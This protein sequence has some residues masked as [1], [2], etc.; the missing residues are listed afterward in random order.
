M[1]R[2]PLALVLVF[3]STINQFGQAAPRPP[4]V[5][6]ASTAP[7]VDPAVAAAEKIA[8]QVTLSE[9]VLNEVQ[10]LRLSEN[11]AH[12]YARIGALLWK[13]DQKTAKDLF[14][15]A[16]NDMLNAQMAAEADEK[17]RANGN[18]LRTAISVRPNIL[19]A[20]GSLDGEF[21]LESLFRTRTPAIQRAMMQAGT[22][23]DGKV[24]DS[25]GNS[26][27]VANN[28]LML[29]QRLNRL[30][31]EQNPDR[32]AKLLQ[33]SIRKGLSNETLGLLRKL[34]QKDPETGESLAGEV[35][36][37]LLGESFSTDP[38]D[39]QAIRLS[40]AILND[41]LRVRKP[42]VKELSFTEPNL[43][44]LANK[45]INYAISAGQNIRNSGLGIPPM[46]KFAEKYSPGMVAALKKLEKSM[47]PPGSAG[48][49]PDSDAR[50]LLESSMTP[51]QLI[52]EAK[53]L[54][55][56]SRAPVYQN[57]ANR[58]SQSGDIDGA[59]ALLS[60]NLSG[61]ALEN[62]V[63]SLNWWYASHLMNQGKWA[64]AERVIDEMPASNRLSALITLASK[65]FAKDASENRTYAVSILQKVRGLMPDRPS[66]NSE[67]G[68]FVQ[69]SNSY[70]TIQPAEAFN[71]FEPVIPILN[72][73]I[74]ANAIVQAFQNRFSVRSDEFVMSNGG[75]NFG[76][77]MDQN[78]YRTLAKADFE[79]TTKLI[80]NFTRREMR[81]FLKLQL[82]ENGLN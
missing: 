36:D 65:A 64:E 67:L 31:A 4:V 6:V 28:E 82:A 47:M 58:M 44:S 76:F 1:R 78:L 41:A 38:S 70:A 37:K 56:E 63:N 24:A 21:A 35:I 43:R 26:S 74:D 8:K 27:L 40:Y 69:L 14:Q 61:R 52:S 68:Q 81:I 50:K 16:V 33:E 72:E 34:Y 57:A 75:F 42:G 11:R 30:A 7:K 60:T 17:N 53:K 45:L 71:T 39:Q 29:E 80:D 62:A 2:F 15:R 23:V 12:A 46:I 66:D 77:Y 55:E 73:L 5:R 9:Q 59:I 18:D 79:R 3:A 10:G 13:S 20:I 32:A 25:S 19:T 48:S 22:T 54:P 51:A 49:I